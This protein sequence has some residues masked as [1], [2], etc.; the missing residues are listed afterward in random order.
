MSLPTSG[1]VLWE[2]RTDPAT[3]SEMR[4][5]GTA[6]DTFDGVNNW[7]CINDPG[8]IAQI[9]FTHGVP[10]PTYSLDGV[11]VGDTRIDKVTGIEYR[12]NWSQWN[13][14]YP[15][16]VIVDTQGKRRINSILGK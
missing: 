8:F 13:V 4:Y 9:H 6:Y 12:Y 2:V 5:I 10:L 1:I 11:K 7:W 16:S 14:N 3:G 15:N